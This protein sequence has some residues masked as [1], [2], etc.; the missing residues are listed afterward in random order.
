MAT[1]IEKAL[2]LG[3]RV[4]EQGFKKVAEKT[5]ALPGYT[6][7]I[8]HEEAETVEDLLQ[9]IEV[10]EMLLGGDPSVPVADV[11]YPGDVRVTGAQHAGNQIAGV[12]PVASD[13]AP[14]S[15]VVTAEAAE[16]ADA[17]EAS[18]VSLG[19][20]PE[21]DETVEPVPG[22]AVEPGVEVSAPGATATEPVPSTE[23]LAPENV[24]VQD[25]S[26]VSE[27]AVLS[28]VETAPA[29]EEVAETPPAESEPPVAPVV[30]DGSTQDEQP[31]TLGGEGATADTQVSDG[32]AP[33]GAVGVDKVVQE[34]APEQPDA[35]AG[36]PEAAD[37]PAEEAAPVEGNETPVGDAA[38]ADATAEATSKQ[39][40]V[41]VATPAGP[42][43]AVDNTQV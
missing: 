25:Q 35:P 6:S 23:E 10:R 7:S 2:S 36:E 28:T 30:A 13:S 14:Q 15:D 21:E 11:I 26:V 43:A 8:L 5:I 39:V 17:N 4:F 38:A 27:E 41:A 34:T 24:V 37:A 22:L 19:A 16:P 29:P 12:A 31:A 42:E 32:V 18:D 9:K 40:E 3:W 20:E 33:N 1:R